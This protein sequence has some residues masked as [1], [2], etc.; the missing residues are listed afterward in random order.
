[1]QWINDSGAWKSCSNFVSS[2][3]SHSFSA[4]APAK[5]SSGSSP[6]IFKDFSSGKQLGKDDNSF[7]F[8]FDDDGQVEFDLEA[9]ECLVDED[10]LKLRRGYEAS[11]R[12]CEV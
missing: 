11:R 8:T 9:S 6:D 1:M 2:E 3:I 7:F 5:D 10:I 4:F 12:S